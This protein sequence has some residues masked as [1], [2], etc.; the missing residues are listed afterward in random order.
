[1]ENEINVLSLSHASTTATE[2]ISATLLQTTLATEMSQFCQR[3]SHTHGS[4]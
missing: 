3:E 4:C 1:M 2:C